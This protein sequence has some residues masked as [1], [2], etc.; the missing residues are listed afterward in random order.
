[1]FNEWFEYS[2]SRAITIIINGQDRNILILYLYWYFT[3]S[4]APWIQD[5]L[6]MNGP[7]GCQSCAMIHCIWS[8]WFS[9]WGQ[10]LL[11]GET[12]CPPVK[13]T[14]AVAGCLSFQFIQ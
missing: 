3:S 2:E 10:E 13:Q 1:M 12:S 11:C 7:P 8:N 9:E 5:W 14:D 4:N 6:V